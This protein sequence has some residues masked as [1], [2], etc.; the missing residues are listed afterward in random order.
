LENK[1][2]FGSLVV[3]SVMMCSAMVMSH[4]YCVLGRN[5]IL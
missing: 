1:E 5:R 3:C 4:G 2:M